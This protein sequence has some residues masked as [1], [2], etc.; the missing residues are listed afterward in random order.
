[1]DDLLK[2]Q[3][4]YYNARA[5]EYDQTIEVNPNP[6][7]AEEQRVASDWQQLAESLRGLG[8]FDSILE[9]ACGTG[10]WTS[11]LREMGKHVTALDGAPEMLVVNCMKLGSDPR[12]EYHQADLFN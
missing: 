8:H 1:M 6:A 3:L 2:Q 9:L 11:I 5:A 4:D 10:A 12:V 7:D